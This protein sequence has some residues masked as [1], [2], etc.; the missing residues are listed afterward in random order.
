[1]SL[2]F[3]PEHFTKE[4]YVLCFNW[5]FPEGLGR[6]RFDRMLWIPQSVPDEQ[7]PGYRHTGWAGHGLWSL[8][9]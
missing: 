4:L 5:V 3:L 8:R 2:P 6:L 9:L 1:M 7:T